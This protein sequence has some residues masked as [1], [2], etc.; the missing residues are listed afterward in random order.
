MTKYE[1][2]LNRTV[3]FNNGL[4]QVG[5]YNLIVS[6]RDVK[7]FKIGLKPHSHW[8]LK[9]V[10]WYFGLKGNTDT[11]LKGLKRL[12][13]TQEDKKNNIENIEQDAK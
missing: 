6:I 4:M 13:A 2:D 8:R 7:L 1:E 5:T 11:I 3:K 12:K 9:D 10:K